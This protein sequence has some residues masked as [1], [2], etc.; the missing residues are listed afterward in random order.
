MS[1][2]IVKV[3]MNVYSMGMPAGLLGGYLL[4]KRLKKGS[5]V[6]RK[7]KHSISLVSASNI[8]IKSVHFKSWKN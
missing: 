5:S 7:K 3:R 8:R 4:F 2:S 1:H 6:K